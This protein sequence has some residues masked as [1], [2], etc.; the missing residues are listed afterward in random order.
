[1]SNEARKLTKNLLEE[2]IKKNKNYSI[3]DFQNYAYEIQDEYGVDSEDFM[4]AVDEIMTMQND[5][6]DGRGNL[7]KYMLEEFLVSYGY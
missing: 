2:I 1:M 4:N 7:D 5:F 3:E 6:F